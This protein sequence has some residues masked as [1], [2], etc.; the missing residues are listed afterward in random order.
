MAESVLC[1]YC[2]ADD[3]TVVFAAGVAQLSQI[4]RCNRCGLMYA[5]PRGKPPDHEQIAQYDPNFDSLPPGSPRES[6]ERLQVK[7]YDKTRVLLNG[8][9]P[10][11]GKLLEV[12]CGLGFLLDTF[13]RDG[14][15]VLGVEPF[16]RCWLRAT[17]EL[18]LEVI[19]GTLEVANL[20]DESFDVVLLNHV[21]EHLDDP[22][23]TLRELNRVLRPNGHLVVET[24]RYDT[25]AF[26]L[27]GR[28]ERS[29]N[30]IGHIYF[31]TT[32]TLK[33]LYEAA[34]FATVELGYVGRSLTVDR[35]FYNL[36][37]ISKSDTVKQ[38]LQRTSRG[39]HLDRLTLYLNL[40]DMQRVCVRKVA[41]AAPGTGTLAGHTWPTTAVS[42]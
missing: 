20:P 35:L 18:G 16:Y 42:C 12:G 1:N 2:G 41:S 5:S 6:K 22:L 26:R 32:E 13:R 11:R 29:I 39:L 9:Y 19:N 7:D 10:Q 37:V 34:G 28:R 36:G 23:H 4:V 33:N 21:I 40:R 3:A 38:A 24:P 17:E 30:C 14:W 25:L 27:L 15:N 31:F 8:L